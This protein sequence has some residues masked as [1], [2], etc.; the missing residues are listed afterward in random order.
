MIGAWRSPRLSSHSAWIDSPPRRRRKA[1]PTTVT[2]GRAMRVLPLQFG[3]DRGCKSAS[4]SKQQQA[5]IAPQGLRAFCFGNY[6]PAGGNGIRAGLRNRIFRVRLSGGAPGLLQHRAGIATGA[7]GVIFNKMDVVNKMSSPGE[8]SA[9]VLT[10]AAWYLAGQG[11]SS[12]NRSTSG[13]VRSLSSSAD[14]FNSHTVRH[15]R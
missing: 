8:A 12:T 13:E 6:R 10:H 15:G 5:R 11:G 1:R 7:R 9:R 3:R 2:D 4:V 14:G